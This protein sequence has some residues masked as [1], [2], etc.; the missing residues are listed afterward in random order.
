MQVEVVVDLIHILPQWGKVDLVVVEKLVT[1]IWELLFLEL[2]LL[3]A[4]VVGIHLEMV[5]VVVPES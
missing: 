3:V 2:M 1:Q 4:E 5:P